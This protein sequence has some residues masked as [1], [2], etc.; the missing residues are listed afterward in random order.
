M[1]IL[2]ETNLETSGN[3][4]YEKIQVYCIVIERY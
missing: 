4:V 2:V 1:M 3:G